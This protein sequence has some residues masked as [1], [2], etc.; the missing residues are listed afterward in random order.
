MNL[1][2]KTNETEKSILVKTVKG[3]FGSGTHYG[4]YNRNGC[5]FLIAAYT[6]LYCLHPLVA[7]PIF[8]VAGYNFVQA[9]RYRQEL[10]K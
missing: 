3:L 7:L 8:A 10:F 5:G 1:E 9:F 6:S 4:V 2:H